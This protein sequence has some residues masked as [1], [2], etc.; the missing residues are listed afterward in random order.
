MAYLFAGTNIEWKKENFAHHKKAEVEHVQLGSFHIYIQQDGGETS[1]LK[2]GDCAIAVFGRME[3]CSLAELLKR[4]LKEGIDVCEHIFGSFIIVIRHG[5][6]LFLIRDPIGQQVVYYQEKGQDISI[7]TDPV[8][9]PVSET[10]LPSLREQ[11]FRAGHI[12]CGSRYWRGRMLLPPG[13]WLSK[14]SNHTAQLVQYY[15]IPNKRKEMGD[16]GRWI[17]YK[18]LCR[19]ISDLSH[20][21][22]MIPS[23]DPPS[24]A[25][26][27][28][29]SEL[30]LP[31][32][33]YGWEGEA[34][35][36]ELG[37]T[38]G[39]SV[40]LLPRPKSLLA[41]Y[42]SARWY[43]GAP[44][45]DMRFLRLYALSSYLREYPVFVPFD[46][47]MG[48]EYFQRYMLCY[49]YSPK[50]DGCNYVQAS[51]AGDSWFVSMKKGRSPFFPQIRDQLHQYQSLSWENLIR[52]RISV[53]AGMNA[54]P[55]MRSMFPKMELP[56]FDERLV[57]LALHL[58]TKDIVHKGLS[59]SYFRN[60]FCRRL[61]SKIKEQMK[62]YNPYYPMD[63]ELCE[64]AYAQLEHAPIPK[65]LRES[66][67]GQ[68]G[69][70]VENLLW[71]VLNY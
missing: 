3:Q 55:I 43:T 45:P 36:E 2:K 18:T 1:V 30:G 52:Y 69:A 6:R 29:C 23:L 17:Y 32:Q 12:T 24:I 50:Q 10:E 11:Y 65:K 38:F 49:H 56:F 46:E 48:G 34:W 58:D 51:Q 28:V 31:L 60:F 54:I 14:F 20:I 53:W 59:Q 16:F 62:N 71:Y 41:C 40:H 57:S 61:S 19:I 13:T 42:Q 27:Q 68:K 9:L 37:K 47:S 5:K 8:G 35:L 44:I 15:R 26:I 67:K 70:V 33:L 63:D 21:Q 22:H 4:Y 7:C 25:L 64:E 39:M 66:V